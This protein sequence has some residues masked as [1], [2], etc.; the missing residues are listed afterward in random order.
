MQ[1]R[2]A[3]IQSRIIAMQT[4]QAATAT[5]AKSTTGGAAGSQFASYLNEAVS[6]Q[7]PKT[8]HK[9]NSKGVPE[10]LAKYGNGKIPSNALA[11][12]GNTGHKVGAP[13]AESLAKKIADGK[14][15]GVNNGITRS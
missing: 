11:N 4:Q 9:L 7:E 1:G 10:D 8:S 3:D 13:A 6:S 12:V 15:E 5:K 14:K 2:I